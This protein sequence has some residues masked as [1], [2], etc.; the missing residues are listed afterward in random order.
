[1]QSS[2]QGLMTS[3]CCL[4]YII[5]PVITLVKIINTWILS[6]T[7]NLR[8]VMITDNKVLNLN[9][10]ILPIFSNITAHINS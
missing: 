5:W 6:Y 8:D 4:S 2:G 3:I 9:Y 1:M 10:E 7:A